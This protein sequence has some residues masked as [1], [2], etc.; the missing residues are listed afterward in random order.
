[1]PPKNDS[2]TEM[3]RA[4]GHETTRNVRPRKIQ[5]AQAP[6]ARPPTRARATAEPV[7]A[8]V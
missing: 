3:T 6:V 2:G 4:H 5:S 8:G 7:T 1:M